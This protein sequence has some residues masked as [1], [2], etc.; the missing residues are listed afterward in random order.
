M[1]TNNGNNGAIDKGG[2]GGSSMR[3]YEIA[4]QY[5]KSS[6]DIIEL[7]QKEGFDPKNHMAVLGEKEVAVLEKIFKEV[8]SSSNKAKIKKINVQEKQE[9][10]MT[11]SRRETVKLTE[12]NNQIRAPKSKHKVITS[13]PIDEKI[14]EKKEIVVSAGIPLEPMLVGKAADFLGQSASDVIVTLLRWGIISAKNQVIRTDVVERL[15]QHYN[16]PI[17]TPVKQKQDVTA[18]IL[19]H[20]LS[21]QSSTKPLVSR[22]PVVVIVGHV[23]HGKTSLLDYIRK[24]RIAEKEKGGITQHIGAYEASTPHGN[25]IFIDTPGH[26]AFSK[27]RERG[28]RIADIAILIVAADDGVMPQTVE[29]INH[30]KELKV[31]VIIAITKMD[32]VDAQ[33]VDVVKRQLAQHD[34]LTEDWGGDVVCVPVSSKTGI[35]IDQLLE[36]IVLQSQLLELKAQDT[37]YGKGYILES[38]LEK[39]RGPIATII[40]KDG[41]ISI[42]DYFIC[43]HV[44][45]RV[46]S[47]I[48][49]VGK[50]HTIVG[51]SV[52]VQVAGF[53]SLARVGDY[54]HIVTKEEYRQHKN[55]HEQINVDDIA[56]YKG[57]TDKVVNLIIKTDTNSS[58]EAL[59]DAI[60][61]LSHR[62][63][64]GFNVIESGVGVITEGDVELAYNTNAHIVALH[65]K[66]E[67]KALALAQ[68]RI[69]SISTFGIIYKLLEYLESYIQSK[70]ERVITFSKAGEA[71]VLRVFDI[72]GV[73]VIAGCR[74]SN[75][76]FTRQGKVVVWRGPEKIGE[77]KIT[78]LQR[79]KRSVKEVLT[80]MEFGFSA[81][82]LTDFQPDDRIE[83]LMES[84]E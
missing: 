77:G 17:I 21:K 64:I 18:P 5:K 60:E 40:I 65:T 61:K 20:T 79:E 1:H 70:Q 78:S 59:V 56:M 47:L 14:N 30:I 55:S 19:Q 27:M 72:K 33:R 52:P 26:E 44:T 42:G 9:S 29:A 4:K 57:S 36:M 10:Q 69:V 35:G 13:L 83:F 48:D 3:I 23:D 51:P 2:F 41:T 25:I 16:V 12:K 75:G 66:A 8:Q 53:D 31:P 45:G 63:P 38:K 58:K 80:G 46:V 43:G 54:F 73:G 22:L 15:A 81:E 62:L 50:S 74:V 34:I 67:G 76:K 71:V 28:V 39:G 49:S 37:G 68:R 84:T 24:T 6:K 7:L 11:S 32:K 82:G